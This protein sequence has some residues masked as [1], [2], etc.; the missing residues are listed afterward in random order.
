MKNAVIIL[1]NRLNDPMKTRPLAATSNRY[2]FHSCH[3]PHH[4]GSTFEIQCSD[5]YC[6]ISDITLALPDR[7]MTFHTY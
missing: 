5:Q 7:R 2:S 4:Y 3:L 6:W 1:K